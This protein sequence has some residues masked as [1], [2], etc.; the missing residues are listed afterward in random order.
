MKPLSSQARFRLD[1]AAFIVFA[2]LAV[3]DIFSWMHAP[4]A[5]ISN[6]PHW[7]R[8]DW[9]SFSGDLLFPVLALACF[10]DLLTHKRSQ[11]K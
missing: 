7:S 9:T 8:Q 1:L 6:W 10:V 11:D 4:P 3:A 2:L 5:W